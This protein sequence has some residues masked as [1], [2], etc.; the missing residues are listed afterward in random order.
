MNSIAMMQALKKE[1]ET[2]F[3]DY[4]FACCGNKEISF[5]LQNPPR[6]R[7]MSEE[8]ELA[9]YQEIKLLSGQSDNGTTASVM[10]LI[11]CK[12][13]AEEQQGWIDVQN[14]IDRIRLR[15]LENPIFGGCFEVKSISWQHA[16][17]NPYPLCLGG[18]ALE[19]E[20]PSIESEGTI[21]D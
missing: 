8:E 17:E 16:E 7:N 18:V 15:F 13:E 5:Y 14:Q 6:R 11:L 20:I 10:I 21:Y 2:L 9:P 3:K 4:Q 19:V 1:L 12:D